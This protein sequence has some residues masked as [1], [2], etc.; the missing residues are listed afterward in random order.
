MAKEFR[1][2]SKYEGFA[3]FSATPQLEL[4]KLIISLVA[5]AQRDPESWFGRR[6]HGANDQVAMMHTDI[7]R[8]YFHAPS[9]EEKYVELP[10]EMW[11]SEYP[12]YGRLRVSLYGTRDA[13]ANW[14]DAYAKVLTEH[15]FSRG[16]ASQCSFCCKERG[17]RDVVHGDDFLSGSPRSQLAWLEKSHGQAL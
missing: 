2:G 6:E 3:N 4:V 7:S 12:E 9:K 14:E 15:G 1:R 13:A 8:A 11:R 16:A 17:I 10:S 5:T